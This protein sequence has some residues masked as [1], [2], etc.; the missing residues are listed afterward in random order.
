[1][2]AALFLLFSLTLSLVITS[3]LK[4]KMR[5]SYGI[6]LFIVYLFFLLTVIL[7]EVKVFDIKIDNV[8]SRL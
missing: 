7:A 4:F 3:F 2:L 1:M 8:L 5:R 6:L